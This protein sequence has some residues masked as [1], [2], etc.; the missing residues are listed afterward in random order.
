MS[1]SKRVVPDLPISLLSRSEV[2]ASAGRDRVDDLRLGPQGDHARA[3]HQDQRGTHKW[4][5]SD[6]ERWM[7]E[8]ER[9]PTRPR[10]CKGRSRSSTWQW[11]RGKRKRSHGPHESECGSTTQREGEVTS[12][13]CRNLSAGETSA[14]RR[15]SPLGIDAPT[16]PSA[17]P[18]IAE[19]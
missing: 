4:R 3:V 16:A 13:R 17:L 6:I 9:R 18:E 15:I 5:L 1:K 14:G 19:T 8:L 10:R 2:A 7:R 12:Q 11:C